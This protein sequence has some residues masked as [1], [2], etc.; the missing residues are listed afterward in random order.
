MINMMYDVSVYLMTHNRPQF[1]KRVINS[2]LAQTF[3]DFNFIVSDNSTN[4]EVQKLIEKENIEDSRFSYIK[5]DCPYDSGIDHFNAIH[6]EV[7]SHYYII[8][9]DDDLMLPDMVEKLYSTIKEDPEIVAVGAFA[10]FIK[11]GKRIGGK[12][13]KHKEIINSS[14]TLISKYNTVEGNAVFASYMYNRDLMNN[15]L[16]EIKNGGKYS[17]CSFIVSLPQNGLVVHIPYRLMEITIHAGQDSQ[18]HQFSE[19]LT[20]LRFLKSI[21]G[22]QNIKLISNLRVFNIYNETIRRHKIDSIPL[23]N[24]K[25]FCLFFKYSPTNYFPRYF[26]RILN[27]YNK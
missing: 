22:K 19:Y 3:H 8:F 5:R 11:N 1:V 16:L 27:L 13:C 25:I 10:Y 20:L 9:H 24:F 18:D 12:M 17:D 6:K 4:N 21:S 26:M 14:I 7:Q 23:F 15:N 2:I